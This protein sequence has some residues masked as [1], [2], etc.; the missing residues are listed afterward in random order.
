[1]S[2]EFSSQR[3]VEYKGSRALLYFLSGT[4][5]SIVLALRWKTVYKEIKNKVKRS[6]QVSRLHGDIICENVNMRVSNVLVNTHDCRAD[7]P[8][9]G[10][11]FFGSVKAPGM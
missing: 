10:L 9:V 8:R 6:R 2:V 3:V 7:C 4:E 1:M 11:D 5:N